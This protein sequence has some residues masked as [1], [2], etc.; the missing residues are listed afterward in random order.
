MEAPERPQRGEM[1]DHVALAV[2]CPSSVP[3]TIP[4]GEL[5]D[6]RQPRVLAQ[7]RLHVVVGVQEHRRGACGGAGLAMHRQASVGGPGQMDLLET[8]VGE[9]IGDPPR[10]AFALLCGVL[11]WIGN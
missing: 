11:P 10:G 8:H 9:R 6:R 2:G 3:A 7:R 4:L 1:H 5:P